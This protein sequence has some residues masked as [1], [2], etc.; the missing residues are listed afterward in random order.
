MR[1]SF[2]ILLLL[3]A[4]SGG[5]VSATTNMPVEVVDRVRRAA[6]RAHV[7]PK[8]MLAIV[9]AESA[10][11]PNARSSVGAEGLMQLMPRTAG[12]LAVPNSYHMLS[13]VRAGC[14]YFRR[15]LT[16]FQSTELAL[17]AYNAGPGNVRKFKGIPPF[18]ETRKYVKR[19]MALYERNQRS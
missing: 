1:D 7:D 13:N 14:E 18:T 6:L 10:Y 5:M 17:A 2:C 3:V 16:E 19:V 9:E 12:E 15:L 11:N 8:L 4:F